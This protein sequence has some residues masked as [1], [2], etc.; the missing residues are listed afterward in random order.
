MHASHRL[1]PFLPA[2]LL[3]AAFLVATWHLQ[4]ESLW[5]D[6]GWSMWAVSGDS[7]DEMLARVQSDVHPPLYFAA[8]DVWVALVGESAYAA[9][10]LS[11]LFG[12]L[13]L[14][15]TYRLGCDLFDA[16]TGVISTAILA[17]AGFFVYY[18][19]EIRMYT[20][21][22]ALAALATLVY[23]RWRQKPTRLRTTAYSLLL[24]ALLYTHYSGAL[25]VL[26]H[27]LHLLITRRV[28]LGMAALPFAVAGGLYLPWALILV[29]QA[30]L[31]ERPLALALPSDGGTIYALLLVATGG[32]PLLYALVLAIALWRLRGRGDTSFL[33]L[34]WLLLTPA[35]LLALNAW[36]TPVYQV[37]YTIASLPA[38]ALLVG[39]GLGTAL[40]QSRKGN[41]PAQSSVLSPQPLFSAALLLALVYMQLAAYPAFWPPKSRYGE[42]V[43]L[44]TAARQ[45]HEP[46]IADIYWSSATAYYDRLYGIR[47]G[48]FVDV[49]LQPRDIER[50]RALA[51]NQDAALPVW[52]VMP[53][54]VARTWDVVAALDETRGVGYRDSVMN[55][56]FYR[57]DALGGDA[58]RL[59]F[60]D[61]VTFEDTLSGRYEVERGKPLCVDVRLRALAPLNDDM[62]ASV[63]LLDADE[64]PIAAWDGSPGIRTRGEAFTLSACVDAPALLPA[65]DMHLQLALYD[66]ASL[67]R[68]PVIE[69]DN[70]YWGD[71]LVLGAVVR[72]A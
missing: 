55:I 53:T 14:A 40:P 42:A 57:F 35:A 52:L 15:A 63:Q 61:R 13:G 58:L 18:S 71:R 24:A 26:T 49:T 36:V 1:S 44:M 48:A 17:A 21:L 67:A 7:P 56:L 32:V 11:V 22:L 20:L 25:I 4:R 8:L 5:D 70:L 50:D 38:G 29:E 43:R 62:A 33:L 37:R 66:R 30:R 47:R 3:L 51:T 60:G 28:R 45:S 31:H 72:K 19:R 9:R 68:L 59:R 6:E 65:G 27:A 39:A 69:D 64:Q 41:K 2:L 23:L 10:L 12:L 54:N 34:L 16:R 46:L